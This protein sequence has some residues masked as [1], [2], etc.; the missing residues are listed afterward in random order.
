MQFGRH[1]HELWRIRAGVLASALVAT[2]AAF[3]SVATIQ[4]TPPGLTS[5]SQE[6]A[7][8]TTRVLIDAPKPSVLDLSVSLT[9]FDGM[10]DR[11]LL[12]GNIMATAPVK[13]YITRRARL[14]AG[15]LEISSPITPD[16]PRALASNGTA[17]HASDILKSPEQHRLSIQVNPTVPIVDIY[18]QAPTVVGAKRLT[19]AAVTGMQDYLRDLAIRDHVAPAQQV[20]L[21]QL[22]SP[23]GGLIN[24]G[25]NRKLAVLMFLLVFAAC[26][27]GVLVLS[28]VRRGWVAEAAS[29]RARRQAVAP[30]S[31]G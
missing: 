11:A 23:S 18:A 5:R 8:A 25:V 21:E 27:A 3:W 1:L 4:L 9:D 14:P 24:Q 22:G 19:A 2:L 17:R 6:T 12:V 28:R 7:A 10:K 30:E 29:D 20:R 16:W 13:A 26:G 31:G 15:V